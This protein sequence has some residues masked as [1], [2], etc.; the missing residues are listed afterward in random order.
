MNEIVKPPRAR[1]SDAEETPRETFD[2]K[3]DYLEG[4]LKEKPKVDDL[5]DTSFME[6]IL[7]DGKVVYP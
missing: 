5:V 6:E 3:R 7:R 1:V 4:F 2:R